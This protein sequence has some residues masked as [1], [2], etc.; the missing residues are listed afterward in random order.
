[1]RFVLF[2]AVA[3]LTVFAAADCGQ[4]TV[5]Q[6]VGVPRWLW[7]LLIIVVPVLGPCL[8]LLVSRSARGDSPRGGGDHRGGAPDDDPEFL[9]HLGGR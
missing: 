4:S 6:R 7:L 2:L 1:M 3:A 8:W 9:H 5:E